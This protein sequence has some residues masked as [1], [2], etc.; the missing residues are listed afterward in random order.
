MAHH[1][2]RHGP[3]PVPPGNLPQGGPPADANT[4][5]QAHG[6]GGAPFQDQDA[7]RR[8]GDFESA[9]GHSRQQPTALND[10][11]QHSK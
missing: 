9:G 1:T 10:G 4:G 6:G 11:Q 8:L 5:A 2:K 3:A 7:K